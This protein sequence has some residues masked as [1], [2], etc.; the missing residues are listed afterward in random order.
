MVLTLFHRKCFVS[1]LATGA[2]SAFILYETLYNNNK[3]MQSEV[4]LW[5]LEGRTLLFSLAWHLPSIPAASQWQSEHGLGSVNWPES[6]SL[7]GIREVNWPPHPQ[8]PGD[9]NMCSL[10]VVE[11]TKWIIYS[12][13]SESG[14]QK[15][16]NSQY[17]LLFQI[18]PTFFKWQK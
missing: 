13:S 8:F 12:C 17:L 10:E 15:M 16:L 3:Q 18:I 4:R 6:E 14:M 5:N 1:C 7:R 2:K 11:K 9:N